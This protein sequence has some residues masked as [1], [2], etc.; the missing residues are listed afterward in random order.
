MARPARLA[1]PA[2][3]IAA[4]PLPKVVSPPQK[5]A[6]LP[7]PKLAALNPTPTPVPT[8]VV[9]APVRQAAL[10]TAAPKVV[11]P[12]PVRKAVVQPAPAPVRK[13]HRRPC[14]C[15][16]QGDGATRSIPG[17]KDR[18]R[19]ARGSRSPSQLCPN[20]PP[21][22][23]VSAAATSLSS[24]SSGAPTVAPRSSA[25]RT[26]RC[27][28]SAPA[29]ASRGCRWRR[30][31]ATWS[32]HRPRPR[33]PAEAAGL[34]GLSPRGSPPR[35]SPSPPASPRSGARHPFG[36]GHAVDDLARRVL[37]HRDAA[38]GRRLLVP[39]AQAVAAE[40]REVHQVDVLHVGPRRAGGRAARG[41]PPPPAR[42]GSRHPWRISSITSRQ[43]RRQPRGPEPPALRRRRS[44]PGAP[45]SARA[46]GPAAG[47]VPAHRVALELARIGLV[48]ADAVA[49][50]PE[51]RDQRQRQPPVVVPEDPRP[52]MAAAGG[53]SAAA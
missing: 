11:T 50:R 27:R 53:P 16:P 39:A 36:I 51:P 49:V 42:S 24:A 52:P 38:R 23:S 13:L 5:A 2:P 47:A 40:A 19:Q 26:A 21:N 31:A 43:D 12:A 4:K 3:K 1:A 44:G 10:A 33:H 18:R 37:V 6:S 17:Q 9:T 35:R 20:R 30:S 7:M 25:C 22:G 41:T 29:T 28:R 48:V 32:S 45:R 15:R 14:S 34:T 8:R 46:A